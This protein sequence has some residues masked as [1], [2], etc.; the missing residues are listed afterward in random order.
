MREDTFARRRCTPD[1]LNELRLPDSPILSTNG[2]CF[3]ITESAASTGLSY[4]REMWHISQQH[5]IRHLDMDKGTSC[6]LAAL[7][8]DESTIAS[9]ISSGRENTIGFLNT[10][11]FSFTT[12]CE[13]DS[14]ISGLNWVD[15]QRLLVI[16]DKMPRDET[17]SPGVDSPLRIRWLNYKKDGRSGF[18]EPISE[19]WLVDS[20]GNKQLLKGFSQQISFL[21]VKDQIAYFVLESRHSD[22]ALPKSE[23]WSIDLNQNLAK[24]VWNSIAPI[25]A[26]AITNYSNQIIAIASQFDG[27][28]PPVPRL[29][30]VD[31]GGNANI[32]LGSEDL[33][34]ERSVQG[35]SHPSGKH[36]LLCS[37][38]DS[39]DVIFAATIKGD[40]AL[41]IASPLDTCP[42]RITKPGWSAVDF[43]TPSNGVI[44]VSLETATSPAELYKVNFDPIDLNDP[45]PLSNFNNNWLSRVEIVNPEIVNIMGADGHPLTGYLYKPSG[46]AKAPLL[47]KIHGGPHLCYGSGFDLETQ[48]AVGSGLCV[49][50]PNLRGSSGF[51][52]EFRSLSVGQWGGKDY[53]DLMTLIDHMTEDQR[54]DSTQ[55]FIQGAS[56][57]GYLTNWT[58]TRT[59][60]FKAAVSER[61]VSNLISK[62]GTSDNGFT[63]NKLE[64]GGADLFNDGLDILIDR[65]PLFHAPNIFTPVLLIHG[66]KDYRCPIEQSEQLFV[67]L[68]RL[69]K[70]AE[71]VRFPG[72]S[73]GLSYSGRPDHRITRMSL[74]SSWFASY[75]STDG[76]S[77]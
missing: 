4:L 7:S 9:V 32:M 70:E 76:N 3:A 37:V 58:L 72:E 11:N 63:T 40:V 61:S 71:F 30:L 57:G 54:V 44:I 2:D 65:S 22:V 66:E 53:E 5:G 49:I 18:I 25:D 75:T 51:G 24:L 1:D 20:K 56:Y 6:L 46:K 48:I 34:C 15:Q 36:R 50:L 73:H 16:V 59:N 69:Q 23:L 67:A 8:P 19:L 10:A 26:I 38:P 17:I 21:E 47:L 55:L 74:I 12:L 31:S 43:S 39:D 33:A 41:F 52:T 27:I 29:W 35:D 62:Y 13:F 64:F 45:V 42:R 77:S 14:A 68:R 28:H 60:K